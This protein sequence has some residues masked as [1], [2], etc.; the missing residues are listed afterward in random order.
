[1][2]TSMFRHLYPFL[3]LV[4]LTLVHMLNLHVDKSNL[5]KI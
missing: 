3:H 4:T 1:M 2:L 5:L